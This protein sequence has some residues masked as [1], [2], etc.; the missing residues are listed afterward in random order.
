[1]RRARLT[2]SHFLAPVCALAL[3]AAAMLPCL[4][5]DSSLE[6]GVKA[7]Y[8]L[9]F[10]KFIDWTPAAFPDARSP[11]EICVLGRDRFGRALDEVLQGERVNGRRLV[12]RRI[13]E[14][15]AAKTCQVLFIDPEAKDLPRILTALPHNVLTV[16]EGDRFI[17][18]GGMIALVVDN[19]RVRFDINQ[20][21]AENAD[22]KLSAKLLSVA[23]SVTK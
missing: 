23:R 16:G 3:T 4:A 1:M 13:E 5:A 20:M 9:N 15:P 19:H 14:P 10:T 12:A 8:L 17:Q 2:G 22:L 18:N 7:A 6:Y 21:A 11:I